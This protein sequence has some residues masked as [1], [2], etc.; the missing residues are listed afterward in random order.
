MIKRQIISF[1]TM[2]SMVF[3]SACASNKKPARFFGEEETRQFYGE[4]ISPEQE[5]ALL[6]RQVYY[7]G[8][9]RFDLSPED[10]LS[11]YAHA[12][13]LIEHPS[14]KIR[15]E[16]H[17]DERGSRE[18]NI[19]LGERRAHSISSLLSLKGAQAQQIIV[20]SYGKEKPAVEGH[21]EAAWSQNRRAEVIYENP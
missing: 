8:Y 4:N 5:Q 11:V 20:L 15:I 16:G 9:D 19:G 2:I 1:M 13:R 6:S 18:Y 12:K 10:T 14:A 17:T 3:C 21:D 7:F